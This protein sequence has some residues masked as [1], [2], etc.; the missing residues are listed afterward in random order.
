[1]ATRAR[2]V[3]TVIWIDE[4]QKVSV[5]KIELIRSI[6]DLKTSEGELVCKVVFVGTTQLL[7]KL[8]AWITTHPEEARAF[9]DRSAF[10][11]VQLHPWSETDIQA[12][13][14]RLAQYASGDN[15]GAPPTQPFSAEVARVVFD[16]AEG[17][18]RSVVQLTRSLLTEMAVH[19]VANPTTPVALTRKDA[20]TIL[21]ARMASAQ[22][23]TVEPKSKQK[24]E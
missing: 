7:S 19:W 18:P 12:W 6:A 24:R 5:E 4:A 10:Y 20:I 21:A 16:I 1:M 2:G 14:R 23:R 22:I 13:W 3:M 9:D 17:K 15:R 8:A 11:S